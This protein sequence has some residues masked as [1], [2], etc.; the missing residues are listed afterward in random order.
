MSNKNNQQPRRDDSRFAGFKKP[1]YTVVPDEVF[2]ELLADLTGAE[3]KVLLYICRR[4][5]GFKKS[6]DTISL[7][8][9][10]DGITTKDGRVLDQGT[11]LSQRHVQRT[12]RSLEEK[13]IVEVD[14]QVSEDGDSDINVYSLKF[15]ERVGTSCP[16]PRDKMSLRVETPVSP[17]TNSIQETVDNTVNGK[18][19]LILDLPDLDQPEGKTEY[20]A[21]YILDELGD[22]H[23]ERFYRLVAAKV[24]EDIIRRALAE[25][26][27]DGADHPARVFTH[28]MKLYA[29]EQMKRQM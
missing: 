27:Q 9:I 25:I 24:P 22:D 15:L 28:R 17:T 18:R 11:G 6:S 19:S 21:Q 12:V 1:T 16:Y 5:F 20:V 3:L 2:D 4:T 29:L 23:S 7:N 10:A 8:Q 26:Q 13:N 14:R